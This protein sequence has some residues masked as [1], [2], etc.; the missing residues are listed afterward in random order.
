[1]K[2]KKRILSMCLIFSLLAGLLPAMSL[3]TSAAATTATYGDFKVTVT[4]GSASVS[5]DGKYLSLAY[6]GTYEITMAAGVTTTSMYIQV[7]GASSS[8]TTITL[9]GVSIES[10][11][12]ALAFSA[13]SSDTGSN[14]TIA[15]QLLGDNSLIS[16]EGAGIEK[17]VTYDSEGEPLYGTGTLRISGTGSLT[18]VGGEGSAGIGSSYGYDTMNIS[19][20]GG[21]IVAIDGN[22]RAD[23]SYFAGAGIGS[24][25][26]YNGSTKGSNAYNITISGGTV[27]ATGG[28]AT[29]NTS[30][31]N[32]S[33]AGIG[34]GG[35]GAGSNITIVGGT[36]T[37]TGGAAGGSPSGDNISGA[38]IGGGGKGAGSSITISGGIVTATYGSGDENHMMVGAGIGGGGF[39]DGSGITI[40][41]GTVAVEGSSWAPAIG[42][43]DDGSTGTITITGGSLKVTGDDDCLMGSTPVN[44]DGKKLYCLTATLQY[45]D[46]TAGGYVTAADTKV[47]SMT[48][49][50]DYNIYDM[51]TDSSG[52]VYLWLPEGAEVSEFRTA[53]GIYSYSDDTLTMGTE[54][55]TGTFTQSFIGHYSIETEVIGYPGARLIAYSGNEPWDGSSWVTSGLNFSLISYHVI[56]DADET[57]DVDSSGSMNQIEPVLD[58]YT[59][60]GLYLLTADEDGNFEDVDLTSLSI[61][62]SFTKTYCE[63]T[64]AGGVWW[65]GDTWQFA[66]PSANVKIVA[67]VTKD[68]TTGV[69]PTVT[70]SSL[71]SATVGSEYSETFAASGDTVTWS[72]S[73]GSLP[74]G[75]TLDGSS[76]EISGTPTA[77]GTYTFTV[78]AANSAGSDTQELSISVMNSV[79]LNTSGLSGA[80]AEL[81][82]YSVTG[83]GDSVTLTITPNSGCEFS[84]APAV[85]ATDATVGSLSESSGVYTCTITG[86]TGNVVIRVSGTAAYPEKTEI[87]LTELNQ[88]VT[89]TGSAQYYDTANSAGVTDGFTVTYTDSAGDAVTDPTDAGIYS[90][91]VTRDGDDTYNA[92]SATGTLT[93]EKASA[94]APAGGEGY[95]VDYTAE[96]AAAVSGY[97]IST[98]GSTWTSGTLAVTPGGTL[99]VRKAET[100][101]T[102]ESTATVNS[103]IARPDAPTGIA[104]VNETFQG[105]SDGQITG[106][107]AAMEYRLSGDTEWIACT[108]DSITGLAS[109]DYEVRLAATASSFTGNAANVTVASGEERTYTLTVTAPA[110][111]AVEEYYT[112]PEAKSIT[113]FSTGNSD[114][115]ITGVTA[116]NDYFA[117][118]GSGDTVTAGGSVSTWTVQPS[119]DLAA[120]TYSAV[121][122]VT[123][124]GGLT[125]T[126]T[127]SFTVIA[128]T[129]HNY[130]VSETVA[131]TYTEQGYTVYTCTDCGESC[132]SDYT[133]ILVIEETDD[134]IEIRQIV[135]EVTEVSGELTSLY[136]SAGALVLDLTSRVTASEGYTEEKSS[137][138]EVVLQYRTN[139]GEWT[140]ATVDNYPETGITVTLPYPEGTDA[141]YDFTV[142]HMFTVTSE[143]LGI[144]AGDT[145]TPTVTKTESGLVFTLTGLSPVAISWKEGV[146]V[147]EAAA[148]NMTDT[149]TGTVVNTSLTE[150]SVSPLTGDS[151][152]MELW[153]I[154]LLVSGLGV[155]SMAVRGEKRKRSRQL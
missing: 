62:D 115:A 34:G 76:G 70:T 94:E 154:L 66:M 30:E 83:S 1:M 130:V 57:T 27:I 89:Y 119:A 85:T 153:L 112:R 53:D 107:T 3:T 80:I 73:S 75:L 140:D 118:G 32:C 109:G 87:T 40:S 42:G 121:I 12:S 151:S 114:A 99:Y 64:D 23:Y 15:L 102:N 54:A 7:S 143:R 14:Q 5:S 138:Y 69:A 9:N 31:Y 16:S 126:A 18:A 38:G 20:G 2:M 13:G 91:A 120:G 63:W 124:Q 79:T 28:S 135:E 22:E 125:A 41:G 43:G 24:G 72:I 139:D 106:V 93:I 60:A 95:T 51:Y 96:S 82:K 61:S 36:V 92:L 147:A 47:L 134:N 44:A 100:D 58:G 8:N 71:G 17:N 48:G 144:T 68:G 145:E 74:A 152:R 123:Y 88:T 150:S 11:A 149:D 33:G 141:S 131:P 67:V 59:L 110:F 148:G 52:N 39:G 142:V 90:V 97:E 49:Y 6:G 122:T 105:E 45:L 65:G 77:A 10:S 4:A 21:T 137:V 116:D 111:D 35:K 78:K 98:D 104:A 127:V 108:G 133:D 55:A 84:A 146:S 103:I 29:D 132:I 50:S 86:F 56:F 117:I 19:I 113:I 46:A 81:S 101:N 128:H 155:F 129:V 25:G 136:S 26:S 37:A